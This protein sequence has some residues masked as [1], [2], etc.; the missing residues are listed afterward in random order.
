MQKRKGAY[1]FFIFWRDWESTGWPAQTSCTSSRTLSCHSG[2]SPRSIR[3]Q[4]AVTA[5]LSYPAKY[6]LL[7]LSTIKFSASASSTLLLLALRRIARSKFLSS[8][9]SFTISSISL[10]TCLWSSHACLF[11]F[12][13]KNLQ[14]SKFYLLQLNWN[15]SFNMLSG[16]DKSFNLYSCTKEMTYLVANLRPVISA[17]TFGLDTAFCS[18][19]IFKNIFFPLM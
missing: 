3:H 5:V 7:Q 11:L 9:L 13:G 16:T 2:C 14:H 8:P 18:S 4:A 17:S 12:M 6:I 19:L 1:T 15:G 10:C